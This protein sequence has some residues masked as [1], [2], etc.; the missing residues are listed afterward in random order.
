[1]TIGSAR[2]LVF[3]VGPALMALAASASAA[4]RRPA[5]VQLGVGQDTNG[6]KL[7]RAIAELDAGEGAPAR[8]R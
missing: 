8:S 6:R 5:L 1:M 7:R 2:R 3:V 4:C